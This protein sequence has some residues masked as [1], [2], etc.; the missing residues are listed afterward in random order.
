MKIMMD[1]EE[2]D[3]KKEARR[4]RPVEGYSKVKAV[5]WTVAV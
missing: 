5:A 4:K 2:G 1:F 3:Q